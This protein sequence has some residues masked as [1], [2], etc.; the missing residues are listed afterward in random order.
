[1][2]HYYKKSLWPGLKQKNGG[3]EEE[4]SN[5]TLHNYWLR[6]QAAFWA[7]LGDMQSHKVPFYLCTYLSLTTVVLAVGIFHCSWLFS[8]KIP[9]ISLIICFWFS[10]QSHLL[11]HHVPL[12]QLDVA[13]I[14]FFSSKT[15]CLLSAEYFQAVSTEHSWAELCKQL[16]LT[17]T[18]NL[19]L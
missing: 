18:E 16:F 7:V 6:T 8:L 9:Q 5:R 15:S 2:E 4:Q 12:T 10:E 19:H 3:G 17:Y 13:E 11:D 1:M 14:P